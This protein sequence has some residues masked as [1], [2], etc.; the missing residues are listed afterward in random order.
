MA[1]DDLE[2]MMGSTCLVG[3]T[4]LDDDGSVVNVR[5]FVGTVVEVDP[6]V[7]ID[8]GDDELFTLPP[9]NEAFSRAEP[10]SY[11]LGDTDEVV[12]DPDF[13]TTWSVSSSDDNG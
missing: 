3:I 8:S 6:I 11:P 4:Y 5:Q 13:L 7:A 2:Q 1:V 12:V 9:E 10:G